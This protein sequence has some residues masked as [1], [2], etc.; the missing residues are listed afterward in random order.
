MIKFTDKQARALYDDIA[1]LR[2]EYGQELFNDSPLHMRKYNNYY[3]LYFNEQLGQLDY[4]LNLY[5]KDGKPT[6]AS[7]I[8]YT[9]STAI[10][11]SML[12]KRSQDLLDELTNQDATKLSEN[13][14]HLETIIR[15]IRFRTMIMNSVELTGKEYA[16]I[17]NNSDTFFFNVDNV[18]VITVTTNGI[19]SGKYTINPRGIAFDVGIVGNPEEFETT[20]NDNEEALEGTHLNPS[21]LI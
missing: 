5:K 8:V 2:K 14:L 4:G 1:Y 16:Y 20:I 12:L 21:D 11:I 17:Y 7:N 15:T 3:A 18:D 9:P 19:E 13:P 6:I 10:E